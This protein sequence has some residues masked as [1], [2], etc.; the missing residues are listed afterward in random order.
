ML[1][2]PGD[3]RIAGVVLAA[4]EGRRMR[5]LTDFRPK[6]ALPILGTS[7]IEIAIR[8]LLRTGA[9]TLHCNLFHL[10][11]QIEELLAKRE[12]PVALYREEELLGTAGGIG[13]MAGGLSGHDL[14]ILHNGDIVSNLDFG[15]VIAFHRGRGSLFTMVLADSGPPASVRCTRD[16]EV[17]GI[18][19]EGGAGD[20]SLGYTGLAV[21][22][23]EALEFFPRNERGGLVETLLTMIRERRGSVAGYDAS[24]E[25][26]W[27]EIG[28]LDRYLGLH[29]RILVG[30]ERFDPLLVPPPLPLYA[31]EDAM[32]EPSAEWRGFLSVEGG[33]VIERDSLLEEC[34]VLRGARAGRGARHRRAVLHP[35]G[36][37]TLEGSGGA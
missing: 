11:D 4:G 12:W 35:R 9:S 23:P 37:M 27:D 16:G 18:G 25:I 30:R 15:P 17:T 14:V 34:V 24:R 21:F 20:L 36:V 1:G 8:K 7:A 13:N 2:Q 19:G 5:P 3:I 22:S 33:G 31:A 28:S 29:G 26:L 6:P 10:P 32:I